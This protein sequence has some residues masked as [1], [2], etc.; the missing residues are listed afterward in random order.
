[1][2]LR[3]VSHVDVVALTGAVSC[4]IVISENIQ[5]GQFASSDPLNIRHQ[6]V[7]DIFRV[8]ANQA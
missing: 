5:V 2:T 8:L 4:G 7:G 6:V 1:M 3:Q